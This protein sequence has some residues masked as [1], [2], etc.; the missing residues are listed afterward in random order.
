MQ[1]LVALN[2]AQ[3]AA[4]YT[5]VNND[6]VSRDSDMLLGA[7]LPGDAE[8]PVT[9]HVTIGGMDVCAVIVRP[10]QHVL[11]MDGRSCWPLLCLQ[12]HEVRLRFEPAQAVADVRLIG[13]LF[14][15]TYVRRAM[16]YSVF[17]LRARDRA[18]TLQGG[19]LKLSP[20]M[21]SPPP[22]ELPE[23][24][25]YYGE[26]QRV[27][28]RAAMF[29]YF[30]ELMS[31]AASPLRLIKW[32]LDSEEVKELGMD[33]ETCE[34]CRYERKWLDEVLLLDG[35]ASPPPALTKGRV[36][37]EARVSSSRD[38]PLLWSG[39]EFVLLWIENPDVMVNVVTSD[40][41]KYLRIVGRA[42]RAIFMDAAK[43]AWTCNVDEHTE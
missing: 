8:R 15:N 12:F 3:I 18:Y 7:W 23:L 19:M 1:A 6:C 21:L 41:R 31:V 2:H 42:G 35:G 30:E 39:A 26:P 28:T 10:G 38:G 20:D 33:E 9:L 24:L 22:N 27:R 4:L 40:A 5:R 37:V 34:P 14:K 11:L 36:V 16:A 25:P 43:C 17:T 29:L 13:A 32:C